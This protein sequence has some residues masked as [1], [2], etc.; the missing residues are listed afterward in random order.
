[1][2]LAQE[3]EGEREERN[4]ER[5]E[6]EVE[7][8]KEGRGL[9]ASSAGGTPASSGRALILPLFRQRRSRTGGWGGGA[10]RVRLCRQS[11]RE[12]A[13]WQSLTRGEGRDLV[14]LSP[15]MM[16]HSDV[17]DVGYGGR[18]GFGDEQGSHG[19]WDGQGFWTAGECAKSIT[20]QEL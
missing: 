19:S 12:L 6:K 20:L 16:I 1:M 15:D 5:R 3:Q 2:S 17:G 9:F 7:G 11:L 18:S 14:H 8:K 13:Y 10:R 4:G